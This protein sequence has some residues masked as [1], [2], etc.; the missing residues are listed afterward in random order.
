MSRFFCETWEVGLIAGAP[1][2]S[3]SLREGGDFD[4][5][6]GAPCLAFFCETWGF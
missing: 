4:F 5:K 3:R 6:P 1:P 2:F